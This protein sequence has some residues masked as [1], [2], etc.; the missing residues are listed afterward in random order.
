[1]PKG[2]SVQAGKSFV[3]A[4]RSVFNIMFYNAPALNRRFIIIIYFC[5]FHR[6]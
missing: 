5:S 6:Q 2:V 1:M 4:G 3:K